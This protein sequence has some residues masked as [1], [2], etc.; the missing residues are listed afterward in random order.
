MS[1]MSVTV[2]LALRDNLTAGARNAA[3][4]LDGIVKSL[5]ALKKA[6]GGD[7]LG[8]GLSNM[9]SG[10][11]KVAAEARQMAESMTMAARAAREMS[12][13]MAGGMKGGSGAVAGIRAQTKALT[14]LAAA[15]QR[16]AKEAKASAVRGAGGGRIG[17]L[18]RDAVILSGAGGRAG[19]LAAGMGVSPGVLGAVV[20]GGVLAKM[21]ADTKGYSDELVRIKNMNL[22]AGSLQ[23]A[24]RAALT[25][26]MKIPGI[27][28]EDVL[29]N[30]RENAGAYGR[31]ETMQLLPKMLQTQLAFGD[32][33]GG[34][35]GKAQEFIK[36]LMR[37]GE[38]SGAFTTK[39]G[40][41]DP[42]KASKFMDVATKISRGT[43]GMVTPETWLGLAKQ[44]G[45][46]LMNLDEKGIAT[47]G[48]L[49][50]YLG[51][52][53]AGTSMMSAYTQLIGGKMTGGTAQSLT[54]LGLLNRGDWKTS[55]GGGIIMSQAAKD[56]FSNMM[57]TDLMDMVHN[58]LLP[59]MRDHGITDPQKQIERLAGIFGRQTTMRMFADLIRNEDQLMKER[60]RVLNSLGIDASNANANEESLSRALHNIGASITGFE[61]AVAGVHGG[62]IAR[63]L[64]GVRS[65]IDGITQAANNHPRITKDAI[66]GA[67]AL[68]GLLAL[69]GVLRLV[70]A[71]LKP[72]TSLLGTAGSAA[73][74]V[75]RLSMALGRIAPIIGGILFAIDRLSN[76]NG[77]NDWK[78]Q[79]DAARQRNDMIDKQRDKAM[80]R[81]GFKAP[82]DLMPKPQ[83][84]KD[85]GPAA[86]GWEK[87][88]APL[89]P[90]P[91]SHWWD[92]FMR[93][94][95]F[96]GM[97]DWHSASATIP[98]MP[99]VQRSAQ[100][101]TRRE[102][103]SK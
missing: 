39:G 37:A 45:P 56:R 81:L 90:F 10:A 85:L 69:G 7:M 28:P 20:T 2:T 93:K 100:P 67:G 27:T 31:E 101:C 23:E 83:L 5:E 19:M 79:L 8:K 12:A 76:W 38:Q 97:R 64:N 11:G 96:G 53:R 70:G 95:G 13:A 80:E 59:A 1:D 71:G 25:L 15:E 74:A 82:D 92:R 48:M 58:H 47:A 24:Q 34:D 77:K 98:N 55:K 36:A 94:D 57:G 22:G 73:G 88:T 32:I 44:G 65:F 35:Y 16:A 17:N 54:D 33:M 75:G 50:Q 52:P 26:P 66:L 21:V 30:Y 14:E 63:A 102:W 61:T 60:E 42:E 68:S 3:K 18:A 87:S 103:K 4:A 46:A 41:F 99:G 49:A 91:E 89:T 6:G 29:K 86:H 84:P 40:V 78:E 9:A 62:E 72:F 51:G 43:G